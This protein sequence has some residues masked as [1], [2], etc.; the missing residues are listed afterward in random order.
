MNICKS[1][2]ETPAGM[3]AL[4]VYLWTRGEN[5]LKKEI[6]EI[7]INGKIFFDSKDKE[8]QEVYDKLLVD[9]LEGKLVCDKFTGE[10]I[11]KEKKCKKVKAVKSPKKQRLL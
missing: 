1:Y 7:H 11:A 4:L 8:H 9:R 2:P 10:E 5:M 3:R 6:K